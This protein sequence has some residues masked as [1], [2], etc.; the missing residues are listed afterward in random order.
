MDGGPEFPGEMRLA[1]RLRADRCERLVRVS[2]RSRIPGGGPPQAEGR[3]RQIRDVVPVFAAAV[4]A[5]LFPGPKEGQ[6]ATVVNALAVLRG[7]GRVDEWEMMT[8][9]LD[10]EAFVV[11]ARMF[12]TAGGDAVEIAEAGPEE[13]LTIQAVD[14][15]P[16]STVR[17]PPWAVEKHLEPIAKSASVTVCFERPVAAD[18]ILAAYTVLRAWGALASFGGFTGGAGIATSVAALHLLEEERQREVSA[19]FETLA[20][21][22]D[23]WGSLWAGLLRIHRR[24]P[25]LRVEMQ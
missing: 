6:R 1:L 22:L 10:V 24:A 3:R 2:A 23:G 17:I 4:D 7:G 11:F 25:I 16:M 15:V 19:T 8:P 13:Q 9:P 20:L 5:G 18:T 14:Q 21:G 12:W